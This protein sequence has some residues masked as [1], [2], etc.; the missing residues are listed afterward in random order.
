MSLDDLADCID[1]NKCDL[2]SLPGLNDMTNFATS[3]TPDEVL[4]AMLDDV[5]ALLWDQHP[6]TQ[7]L[8][9]GN[10]PPPMLLSLQKWALVSTADSF[11][12]YASFNN[13]PVTLSRMDIFCGQDTFANR[14][15]QLL[16]LQAILPPQHRLPTLCAW[17]ASILD[18][19]S[20]VDIQTHRMA[21]VM[22]IVLLSP[23]PKSYRA[24]HLGLPVSVT[25]EVA[26]TMIVEWNYVAGLCDQLL[27]ATV[28]ATLPAQCR[29][30]LQSVAAT[31]VK[32]S[33]LETY[34]HKAWQDEAENL[35]RRS[36]FALPSS[37]QQAA[38]QNQWHMISC[39][40]LNA[41]T[42]ILNTVMY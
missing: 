12:L 1:L 38:V 37:T 20:D 34:K 2:D 39:E 31:F 7:S 33:A 3:M 26:K 36:G 13:T 16:W 29:K 42:P 8:I 35:V 14:K 11:A 41:S 5:C 28:Q 30:E 23:C 22:A 40:F 25:F 24:A 15:Q 17:L 27:S 6:S 18:R 9:V 21:R 4:A 19:T 10:M 32:L